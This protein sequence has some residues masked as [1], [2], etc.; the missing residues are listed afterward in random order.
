MKS[1]PQA[2]KIF[3]IGAAG[4]EIFLAFSAR[5]AKI[6]Q[7]PRSTFPKMKSEKVEKKVEK[8]EKKVLEIGK[9]SAKIGP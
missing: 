5:R 3:E 8:E 9:K 7:H 2:P 1:A 4:A 6:F